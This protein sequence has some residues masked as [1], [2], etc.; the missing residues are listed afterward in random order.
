MHQQASPHSTTCIA[1]KRDKRSFYR[2]LNSHST[3][4]IHH[5][6]TDTVFL[7]RVCLGSCTLGAC[8]TAR[9]AILMCLLVSAPQ[10]ARLAKG[11]LTGSKER[12][13]TD[14][15]APYQCTNCSCL[16]VCTAHLWRWLL[17]WS[18]ACCGHATQ[19]SRSRTH[20]AIIL[21]LI[22]ISEPTRPY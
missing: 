12:G 18:I 21:S 13:D 14:M 20:A 19:P 6:H 3:A 22:H 11:G 5:I 2:I 16:A 1:L 8:C 17:T 10:Y 9:D 4:P 7:A 15:F